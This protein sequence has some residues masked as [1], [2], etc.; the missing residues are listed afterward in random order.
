MKKYNYI[1][2]VKTITMFLVIFCHCTLFFSD[3]PYWLFNADYQDAAA[4]FL[5]NLLTCTV[6]PVFVFCSGFLFQIS[7]QKKE[8]KLGVSILQ[9]AKRLLIPFALYGALWLVPTY[10]LLDIPS[11]GRPEGSSLLLSYK[12]WLLGQFSDVSWFLLMLLW[13]SIIWILCRGLLKKKRFV[14]GALAA[15]ALYFAAHYLLGGINH[16]TLNQIDVYIVIFFV[17]AS[18][19]WIADKVNQLP[20]PVLFLIAIFGIAGCALLSPY[21][22]NYWIYSVVEVLMSVLMILLSMGLCRLP[23]HKYIEKSRIYKWLL[24]NNM[25]IYLLQAPGMYISFRLLYPIIG[26]YCFLCILCCF[27]LTV[28]LDFIVVWIFLLIKRCFTR[29]RYDEVEATK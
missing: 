20:V 18:F 7:A 29:A 15:L 2:L 19:Y 27:L 16:Y 23:L 17:G 25:N 3:N 8:K 28:I 5:C 4:N 26:S 13:V 24:D 12:S 1:D 9:R 11:Y 14:F 21:T 6:V 10:T 22:N